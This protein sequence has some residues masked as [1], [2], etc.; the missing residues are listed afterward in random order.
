[1]KILN[2]PVRKDDK[3]LRQSLLI[4]NN[5]VYKICYD[6]GMGTLK[7]LQQGKKY[8]FVG[9]N[10]KSD[11]ILLSLILIMIN[12]NGK[13]SIK[14]KRNFKQSFQICDKAIKQKMSL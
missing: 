5:L 11:K 14:N 13:N 6:V 2:N 8:H 1:M 12:I 9:G 7:Y 4:T 3:F 10:K